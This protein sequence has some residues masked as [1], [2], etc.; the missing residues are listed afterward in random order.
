FGAVL[1][2]VLDKKL[3]QPLCLLVIS[4]SVIPSMARIEYFGRYVWTGFRHEYAEIWM[5]RKDLP[6]ECS[7]YRSLNHSSSVAQTD[8]LPGTV[9]TACPTGI[10]QPYIHIRMFF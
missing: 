2:K 6:V 8:S 4:L 10:D 3:G 7:A 1:F 5:R 9:S